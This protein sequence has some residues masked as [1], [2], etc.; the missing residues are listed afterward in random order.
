MLTV[1]TQLGPYTILAPLGP[2][3]RDE[4]P[5]CAERLQRR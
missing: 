4:A 1:G 2:G 3:G 5:P